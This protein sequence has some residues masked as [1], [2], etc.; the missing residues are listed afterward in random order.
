MSLCV[1]VWCAVFVCVSACANEWVNM[2]VCVCV[3]VRSGRGCC[4]WHGKLTIFQLKSIPSAFFGLWAAARAERGA[5]QG[6]SAA[7]VSCSPVCV[8]VCVCLSAVCV[9]HIS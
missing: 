7:C 4:Y 9:V 2:C 3:W 6:C 1:C 5:C 8:C